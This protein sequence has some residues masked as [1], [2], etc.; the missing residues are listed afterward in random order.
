[1]SPRI[2]TFNGQ[3]YDIFLKIQE[4]RHKLRENLVEIDNFKQKLRRKKY[5]LL[6]VRREISLIENG[7]DI[8]EFSAVLY[9]KKQIVKTYIDEIKMISIII[10]R[11]YAKRQDLFKNLNEFEIEY[12]IGNGYI[13]DEN[14]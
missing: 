14:E 2:S 13:E 10:C 1:M 4:L 6:F 8:L 3:C 9:L 7:D 12:E 5:A 11:L